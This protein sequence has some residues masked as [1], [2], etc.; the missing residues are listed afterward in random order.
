MK[1]SLLSSSFLTS[2]LFNC[3]MLV[4]AELSSTNF[5]NPY[6]VTAQVQEQGK[7][8]Q[9]PLSLNDIFNKGEKSVVQ[10]T[11]LLFHLPIY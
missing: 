10:I 4:V 6:H 5:S 8:Q 11:K 1:Q 9:Q 3:G 2:L 7:R